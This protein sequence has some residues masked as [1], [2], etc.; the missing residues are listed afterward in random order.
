M[1][2]YLSLPR[3]YTAAAAQEFVTGHGHEGRDEGTGVGSAVIERSTGRL[4]GA[5]AVRLTGNPEI[6]YWVAPDARGHGYAAEATRVLVDWAF[7]L[8][9]PRAGLYCQV[10]NLASV[11][12][13]LAAG[14]AFEGVS[15][16]GVLADGRGGVSQRH[17]DLARFAR[18]AGDPGDPI[19]PAFP[20]LPGSGLSDGV[21]TLRAARVEDAAGYHS[22]DDELSRRWSF[23]GERRGLADAEQRMARAG[24]V[25]LVGPSAQ[26]TIVDVATGGYAGDLQ[27]R[28][29]GPPGV[30]SL[31][32]TVH[33][34]FRGRGYT[35]R[36]LRLIAPWAFDVAGYA[37]LELGAKR[38]NVASQRAAISAGFAPDG[39]RERRL[40]NADGSFSDEI[41]FALLA[42]RP[43]V[44]PA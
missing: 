23:D 3:P 21:I 8:G 4:V 20:A 43:G 5:C 38:A 9:V 31:G 1:H 28:R 29:D 22:S 44:S 14:L 26:C 11:R 37:R 15:R 35:A 13:A 40:R 33:P 7:G 10:G 39:V 19:A 36:A 2:D 6:G 42:P 41:C 25:W 18:L 30:A 34:A 12:T 16:S 32:Y 17:A 24:L 27:I